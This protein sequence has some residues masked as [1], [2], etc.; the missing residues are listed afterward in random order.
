MATSV[1]LLTGGDLPSN[2]DDGWVEP[3]LDGWRVTITT[4]ESGVVVRTRAGKSISV[5]EL[6]PMAAFG[7]GHT[8]DA[9]L[10]HG[11][12]RLD[13]FYPLAGTVMSACRP[14]D[15]SVVVFDVIFLDGQTVCGEPIEWR[16][17]A[18]VDMDVNGPNWATVTR[19]PGTE[20]GVL[21]DA[22]DRLGMEGIVWKAPAS[23]YRPGVRSSQWK[24][25]KTVAWRT[26]HAHRR[27]PR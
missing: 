7:A 19:L 8:F 23:R 22:C 10:I 15:L 20:R 9:E 12:G 17:S 6:E 14:R 3:K 16:R 2:A 5:D 13:D 11:L 26:S 24:K 27:R 25:V 1:M 4:G 18:L 21:L